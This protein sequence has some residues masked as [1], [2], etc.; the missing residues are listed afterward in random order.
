[1]SIKK[2][3]VHTWA[4][5]G[6]LYGVW[7]TW[8]FI[9]RP[10]TKL[11]QFQVVAGSPYSSPRP[12]GQRGVCGWLHNPSTRQNPQRTIEELASGLVGLAGDAPSRPDHLR[13]WEDLDACLHCSVQPWKQWKLPTVGSCTCQRNCQIN[14]GVECFVHFEFPSPVPIPNLIHSASFHWFGR[15]SSVPACHPRSEKEHA[16]R[17]AKMVSQL[18][19]GSFLIIVRTTSL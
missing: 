5:V 11:C 14:A 10:I 9:L 3:I 18:E 8:I 1:M 7:H 16:K 2:Y 6:V 12:S 17:R 19:A 13:K 4:I 15:S